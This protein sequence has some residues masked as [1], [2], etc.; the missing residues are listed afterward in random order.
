MVGHGDEEVRELTASAPIPP[1]SRP[2]NA[3]L[4]LLPIY[5]RRTADLLDHLADLSISRLD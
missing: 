2:G 3:R 4:P 5:L 1:G